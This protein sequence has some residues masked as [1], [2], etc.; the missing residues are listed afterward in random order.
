M[1]FKDLLIRLSFLK[2]L[3]VDTRTLIEASIL[4]LDGTDYSLSDMPPSNMVKPCR[5]KHR[6]TQPDDDRAQQQAMQ[7]Q[8]APYG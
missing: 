8:R 5:I 4:S 7:Q 3:L 6:R 2:D 1:N